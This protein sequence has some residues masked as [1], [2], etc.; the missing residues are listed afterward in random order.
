MPGQEGGAGL[1][2][3]IPFCARVCPYC[4]FAVTTGDRGRHQ[5][6]LAAL[7]GELELAEELRSWSFNT[8]YLGGGTPSALGGEVLDEVFERL[9][10]WIDLGSMVEICLEA[11]PEDV[12][13]ESLDRWLEMGVS[14]LSLGIQSW[15]DD[16]LKF[17]GRGH[18]GEMADRTARAAVSQGFEVVSVDLIYGLPVATG[19]ESR[20]VDSIGRAADCG[21]QH[22]SAYQLTIEPRTPF[23]VRARQG[24]L[25]ELDS[26]AQ[27]GSF[28]RVHRSLSQRGYGAYEV[29][30]FARL[31][32]QR[33]RHNRKYWK[34]VPY[35][36][37]GPSAHSFDGDRRWSNRR[38]FGE[39][40]A[41]VE[42]GDRPVDF[43]EYL[44]PGT[45]AL[46]MLMLGLRTLDGVDLESIGR[47]VGQDLM[48][49]NQDLIA[50]WEDAGYV[51]RQ[52]QVLRPTFSGW[53]IADGMVAAFDL[54]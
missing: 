17:L 28:A 38:S 27:A 29:S 5:R 49:R 9:G 37:L 19:L 52:D 31:E 46:E 24:D 42:N 14:R 33:S 15:D 7:A 40:A 22:V 48:E 43:V 6:Y 32:A 51:I 1:Y 41:S 18:D 11:N 8:L 45:R 2:V 13:A 50:G 21:V 16:T 20:V 12:S 23:G 39:W 44:T 35:L 47:I 30:S 3:H 25:S 54:G 10:R 4:D 53:S 36:G 26:D 34:Q